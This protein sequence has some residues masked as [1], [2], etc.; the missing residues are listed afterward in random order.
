VIRNLAIE[1]ETAK[2]RDVDSSVKRNG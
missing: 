2:P 1:T